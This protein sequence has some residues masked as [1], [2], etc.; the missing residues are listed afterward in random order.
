MPEGT[1]FCKAIEGLF[2]QGIMN[3]TSKTAFEPESHLTRALAA[4]ILCNINGQPE[5]EVGSS[6]VDVTGVWHFDL[7]A[8]LPA[9]TM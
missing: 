5:T 3:E 6:S 1:W 9:G 8:G 7:S 2:V 4:Q